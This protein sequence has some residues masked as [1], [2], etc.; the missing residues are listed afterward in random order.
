MPEPKMTFEQ[1]RYFLAEADSCQQR[2]DAELKKKN[3]YPFMI[4]YYEGNQNPTEEDSG[5]K[6]CIINEYFPSV[7]ALISEIMYQNPDII[8]EA[9][10]PEGEENAPIMRSALGYAFKKVDALTENR[11]GLFDMIMAGYCA[12]DVNHINVKDTETKPQRF[13]KETSLMGKVKDFLTNNKVEEELEKTLPPQ[14]IA[15]STPDETYFRRWNPLDVLFDYQAERIKDI[16]YTIKKIKWTYAKFVAMYPQYAGK[17]KTDSSIPFSMQADGKDKK[18]VLLYEFQLKQRDR[19]VNFII[20]PSFNFHEID[21]FERP[22]ITNGFNLKIGTLSE[23]GVLYPVS[24]AQINKAI[25]DDINNYSTFMMQVAERNIPKIGIDINKVK[26]DGIM[27]LRSTRVNDL[28]PVDG[29]PANAIHPIQPTAVSNENKELLA[30]FQ[31]QKEKLWAVSAARQGQPS[32]AEFMGEL[33]IQ[34]AGFMARQAD[35]QEGLRKLIVSEIETL[36][37]IIVQ[38][39]DEPMWFKITGAGKPSWYIPQIVPNPQ[40]PGRD[41]GSKRFG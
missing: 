1:I 25:Q 17:V 34:E 16:R 28:V 40:K 39:W 38:F 6:L 19:F 30:I 5:K 20:T 11:L 15:Y 18:T 41:Y 10:K 7:N 26:D 13:G 12:I 9:S 3:H 32:K 4:K 29:I 36:K 22:Y 27:G 8:A 23:Y 33:E 37:D 2:Q 31:Q 35:I 24:F 21:Y 14:E